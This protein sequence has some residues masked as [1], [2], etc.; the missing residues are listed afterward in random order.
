MFEKY[1]ITGATGFLGSAVAAQL[2]EKG[3]KVRA[4]VL[5][6]DPFIGKLPDT[7]EIVFGDLNDIESLERFFECEENDICVIHC[8]GIISIASKEHPK[9]KEVNI[10]G[11]R[12]ILSL[13]FKHKIKKLVYVSS[14]HAIPEGEKGNSIKEVSSFSAD[15]VVGHY[16]KSKA[17]ATQLVLDAAAYGLDASVVH[18]SGII[19]PKDDSGGNFTSMLKQ[20]CSGKLR[21]GVLGGYDFVDVRDVAKGVI[22]CCEKGR[23]G[24]C[25]ILSNRYV[26]IKEYLETVRAAIKGKSILGYLPRFLAA[27]VAP[28]FE[29]K[30]IKNGE[31]LYFT[32]YS[33]YTLGAN[34]L[35]SH[36]KASKELDYHPR[37]L[38]DTII[39]TIN[40]LR[41]QQ[42]AAEPNIA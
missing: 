29:K 15:C 10:Q 21:F 7:A 23:S 9:L 5:E 6:N 38:K 39:D 4:L 40:W 1:L 19:G 22:S 3:C 2:A 20:Y 30:S 27:L 31:P 24:E 35:F 17:Q 37:D 11:T 18:P 12:N 25:Y 41:A 32:P 34:A 36:E 16:A 33:I 14:V 28:I 13:C 26:S 8:A 42:A